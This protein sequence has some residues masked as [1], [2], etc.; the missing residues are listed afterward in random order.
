MIRDAGHYA[1]AEQPDVFH[2][3]TIEFLNR[4]FGR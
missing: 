1:F 4:R 2:R 3:L